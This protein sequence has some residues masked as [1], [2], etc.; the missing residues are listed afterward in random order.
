MTG[1]EAPAGAAQTGEWVSNGLVFVLVNDAG[2]ELARVSAKVSCDARPDPLEAALAAGAWFPLQIGNQWVYRYDS[3]VVTSDYVTW[4]ITGLEQRG[5]RTYYV[6]STRPGSDM[7]LRNDSDGRVYRI[8]D[9]ATQ[10]EEL[11]LD[12]TANPDPAALLT[13]RQRNFTYTSALGTF[14]GGIIY[15]TNQFSLIRETGTFVRGLGLVQ[16]SSMLLTGSS[17]GFT[18]GLQLVSVRIGKG[19]RLA[20]D[21]V[22]FRIG[23]E[24]TRLDVTNKKVTNCAI[25]CYFPAC[26]IGG[27]D[28]VNTYKPCFQARLGIQHPLDG[29]VFSLEVEL[30]DATDRQVFQAAIPLTGSD[31]LAD[32]TA[33]QQVPLYAKP[34]EPFAAG[35]YRLNGRL[36]RNGEDAGSATVPIRI[37]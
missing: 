27:G 14:S 34:N 2:S 5:D 31:V 36:K 30:R 15:E 29:S 8:R 12:P 9:A 16:R 13:I 20:T 7:L 25:P 23:V 33:F 4:T 17:G 19:I 22:G 10:T 11:W 26:G 24:N 18:D 6:L 32:F 1:R 37:D 3:R 21:A 28:P 35:N